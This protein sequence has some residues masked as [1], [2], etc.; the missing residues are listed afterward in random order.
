MILKENKMGNFV[1]I[2]NINFEIIDTLEYITLADSF[3]KNKIYYTTFF[4][5]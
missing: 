5:L 4:I 1:N 2:L 3:V